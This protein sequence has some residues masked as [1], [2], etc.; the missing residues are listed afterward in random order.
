MDARWVIVAR[1]SALGPPQRPWAWAYQLADSKM[2]LQRNNS[3]KLQASVPYSND[4]LKNQ[5]KENPC[6]QAFL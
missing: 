4:F 3:S 2:V 5:G 1:A 6:R